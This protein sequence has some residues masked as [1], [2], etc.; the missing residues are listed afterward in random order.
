[1]SVSSESVS[2]EVVDRR[3][4]VRPVVFHAD[5]F[6]FNEP[7]TRGIVQGFERGVL[8]STSALANAPFLEL[9]VSF[10]R[11]LEQ[12]RQ[13]GDLPSRP[14]RRTL[15]DGL[16]PFDFGVH[17]NLTQGKPLTGNQYPPQLL[18]G[19]G[20]FPGVYALYGKLSLRPRRFREAIRRELEAQIGRL[21]DH[22]LEITQLNGHQYVELIP[23]VA[24]LIPDLCRHF[25]IPV[26]RVAR[27]TGFT[28]ITLLRGEAEQWVTA[29][30]KRYYAGRFSR[31][32]HR[33]KLRAP[34]RFFGTSHTARIH[35]TILQHYLNR[36]SEFGLSE[37][38][39]HPG[40]SP[41]T[42]T[43]LDAP[44]WEDPFETAR[45]KELQFIESPEC[46][47]LLRSHR[48]QLSRL[49]TL[50]IDS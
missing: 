35:E 20:F 38:C 22:S 50:T 12:R 44:G 6:G 30:M 3:A 17:L 16:A 26:V 46:F 47:D 4:E 32:A 31:I 40:T 7:I 23:T 49:R 10:W 36:I 29:G 13:A 9:G 39:L 28:P 48:V 34:D 21:R 43:L 8:T 41:G 25:E 14:L 24:R 19:Q 11:T 27:E 42:H 2:E 1:M 18:D 5:D 37:V 15:G 45:P 33:A